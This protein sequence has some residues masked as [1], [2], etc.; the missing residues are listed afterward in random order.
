MERFTELFGD[1]LFLVYHCF[2]RIVIHGYLS[3]L[4]RPEQV[5]YFLRQVLGLPVVDK[6]V[7]SQRTNDYKGWVEAY[8]RH[9]HIPIEWAEKGVR[10]EVYVLP[11]L[12]RMEKKMP[13]A[14]TS[15]SAAWNWA[16]L[17]HQRA[18]VS[19]PG[20]KLPHPGPPAQP[21]YPRLFLHS[22]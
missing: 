9:H 8:A 15:C 3:G 20:P 14:S 2:D 4:S 7:L 21:L 22:G 19:E 17:P 18:Q 10:K 5:V 6:Q 1:L 13:L 11:A 12:R 16:Y